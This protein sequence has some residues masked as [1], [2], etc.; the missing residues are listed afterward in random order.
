[1][2][3]IEIGGVILGVFPLLI[4]AM[5]KVIANEHSFRV[6]DAETCLQELKAI[7]F[8]I[9]VQ[10]SIFQNSYMQLLLS[11]MERG[12]LAKI[13]AD[14]DG[15]RNNSIKISQELRKAL[16]DQWVVYEGITK[17]LESTMIVLKVS[18][19]K[20]MLFAHIV[21]CHKT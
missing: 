3:G 5:E 8:E 21:W 10:E 19:E 20:V 13:M 2:S 18:V 15:I 16:G 6:W 11:I 7:H 9:Q 1:M 17:R 12:A 4:T 14:P